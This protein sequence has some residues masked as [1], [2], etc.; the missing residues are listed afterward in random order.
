MEDN[1]VEIFDEAGSE[2]DDG[3]LSDKLLKEDLDEELALD[4]LPV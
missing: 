2:S 4:D 1:E 3:L